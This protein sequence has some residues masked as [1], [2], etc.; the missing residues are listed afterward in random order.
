M[1]IPNA[2]MTLLVVLVLWLLIGNIQGDGRIKRA[3]QILV[4][5]IAVLMLLSPLR[6]VALG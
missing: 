6:I 1:L 2:L 3:A 4:V 5:I